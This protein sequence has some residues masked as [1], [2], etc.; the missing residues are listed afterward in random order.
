VA[1]SALFGAPDPATAY[2]EI[3]AAAG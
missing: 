1:G 3:A 2:R